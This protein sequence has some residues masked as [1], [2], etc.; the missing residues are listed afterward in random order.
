MGVK[1]TKVK[2]FLHVIGC[3]HRLDLVVDELSTI[4]KRRK[5]KEYHF[6]S[7]HTFKIYHMGLMYVFI[8]E[9]CKLLEGDNNKKDE[10][11]G[12]LTKLNE[13]IRKVHQDYKH[14]ELVKSK[15][16][17]LQQS[18]FHLKNI[19][20]IRDSTF[21]HLDKKGE[22]FTVTAFEDDEFKTAKEHV[23]EMIEILNLCGQVYNT[24][25]DVKIRNNFTEKFINE[26]AK[27]YETPEEML[28]S[29]LGKN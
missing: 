19:R 3:L 26:Y 10:N 28:N 5:G 25:Y 1:E 4:Y 2:N 18:T 29:F 16:D 9:Y 22:P 23:A 27:F 21:A 11:W 20:K 15:I 7:Q 8:C 14:Y 12:S 24:D 6:V 13:K 17:T